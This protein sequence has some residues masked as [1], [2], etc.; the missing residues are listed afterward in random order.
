MWY[1]VMVAGLVAYLLG[2]LNGAV[3]ISALMHDDVRTHGSGNEGLTNI[4]RN[5]GIGQSLY[6]ILIDAGKAYLA[7]LAGGLI[8]RPYGLTLEGLTLGGIAVMLGHDYP[9]LLGF[10]GGKGI[11]SGL[12]IALAID[13]RIALLILAVFSGVYLLT[14]Y[15]S[16]GSVLAALTFA[17]GFVLFHHDNLAVMLGGIFMGLLTVYMH[18]GNISRLIRGEER[19][20]DLFAKGE[21]A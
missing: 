10:R 2:N 11:L 3:C 17:L 6:V 21:Q 14:K 19:K 1:S 9:A 7:C 16:L 4:I 18:R 15:V 12:F 20:T 5:Y 8:L 13:W